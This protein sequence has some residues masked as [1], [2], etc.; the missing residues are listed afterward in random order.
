[1]FATEVRSDCC[2]TIK[3]H[4]KKDKHIC[5]ADQQKLTQS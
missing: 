2:F 4:L 5:T 3:Q 1:V